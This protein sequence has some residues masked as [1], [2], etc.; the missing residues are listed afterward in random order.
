[1]EKYFNHELSIHLK[2]DESFHPLSM[3]FSPGEEWLPDDGEIVVLTKPP[4]MDD[5]KVS[6]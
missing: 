2:L 6:K 4:T 3:D 5:R 1:M